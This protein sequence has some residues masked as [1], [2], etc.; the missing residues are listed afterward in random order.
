MQEMHWNTC[1]HNEGE[2]KHE[3]AHGCKATAVGRLKEGL[4]MLH[5]GTLLLVLRSEVH[6]A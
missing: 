1:L 6:P 2:G 5:D 3:E 4:G